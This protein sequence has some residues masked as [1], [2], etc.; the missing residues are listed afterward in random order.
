MKTLDWGLRGKWVDHRQE[1]WGLSQN[2]GRTHTDWRAWRALTVCVYVCAVCALERER[3]RAC[4]HRRVCVV[5]HFKMLG[6]V[7]LTLQLRL[8]I[9]LIHVV[10]SCVFVCDGPWPGYWQGWYYQ[11]LLYSH[12]YI[13]MY[14]YVGKKLNK[15][16]FR[17]RNCRNCMYTSTS[18]VTTLYK[19][20]VD[21]SLPTMFCVSVIARKR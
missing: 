8:G 15:R 2:M 7:V 6:P 14:V 4:A 3:I 5:R 1:Q 10:S 18:S 20:K 16:N 9:G 11:S 19:T 13:R 12:G 17:A 21:G